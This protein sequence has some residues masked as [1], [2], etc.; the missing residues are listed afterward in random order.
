MI[1]GV[2]RECKRT[3]WLIA[4]SWFFILAALALQVIQIICLGGAETII[5][6]GKVNTYTATFT[7]ILPLS[8]DRENWLHSWYSV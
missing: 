2:T 6:L 5:N 3:A 4:R 1:T 7:H 8:T